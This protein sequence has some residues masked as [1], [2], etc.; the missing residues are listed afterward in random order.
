MGWKG[1]KYRRAKGWGGGWI[2]RKEKRKQRGEEGGKEII[3]PKPLGGGP[4]K[5][6]FKK[7]FEKYKTSANTGQ[8]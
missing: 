7:M 3:R 8:I 5:S 6:P 1:G 4:G 2:E